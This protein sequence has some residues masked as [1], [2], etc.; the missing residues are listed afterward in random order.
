[1]TVR[2]MKLNR[3]EMKG[4]CHKKQIIRKRDR[5]PECTRCPS[6]VYLTVKSLDGIQ[7]SILRLTSPLLHGAA[8]SIVVRL[9]PTHSTNKV[10]LQFC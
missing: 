8:R 2:R 10:T 6:F 9:D 7:L 1:M 3:E 5:H 4:K